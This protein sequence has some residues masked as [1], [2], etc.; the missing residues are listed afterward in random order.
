MEERKGKERDKK[1][2]RERETEYLCTTSITRAFTSSASSPSNLKSYM[3]ERE[4]KEREEKEREEKERE[5]KKRERE[6]WRRR[7]KRWR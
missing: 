3:R 6:R 7:R 5:E 1:Y 4:E 2:E